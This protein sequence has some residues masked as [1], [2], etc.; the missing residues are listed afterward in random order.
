[1]STEEIV[2]KLKSL[3]RWHTEAAEQA[4]TQSLAELIMEQRSWI[5]MARRELEHLAETNGELKA[6][7]VKQAC[8]FERIEAQHEPRWPLME[9]DDPGAAL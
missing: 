1:M 7:L 5:V 8:Y 9:G 2:K 3:A 4:E 6:R